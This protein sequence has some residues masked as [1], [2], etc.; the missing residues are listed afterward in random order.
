MRVESFLMP[1]KKKT[2]INIIIYI[3]TRDKLCIHFLLKVPLGVEE[4]E[5]E[6]ETVNHNTPAALI[7]QYILA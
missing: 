2:F 3:F 7:M 1:D 6:A 4:R 5:G